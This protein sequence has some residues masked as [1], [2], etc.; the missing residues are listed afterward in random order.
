MLR[1][2]NSL[3]P[4]RF[5]KQS[6][7]RQIITEA[8]RILDQLPISARVNECIQ[9]ETTEIQKR[10][11]EWTKEMVYKKAQSACGQSPNVPKEKDNPVEKTN[12]REGPTIARR[13]DF[14]FR[15]ERGIRS[16]SCVTF[17]E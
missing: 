6:K 5:L 8:Q 7:T 15:A 13:S 10:H 16:V 12:T 1:D 14:G 2:H 11:P 4:S 9:K 3:G 17:D